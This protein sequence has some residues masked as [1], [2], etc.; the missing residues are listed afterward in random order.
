M[1]NHGEKINMF[2]TCICWPGWVCLYWENLCTWSRVQALGCTHLPKAQFFSKQTMWLVNN[3][4]LSYYQ[5]V[6][7]ECSQRQQY[8]RWVDTRFMALISIV[9]NSFRVPNTEYTCNKT[10]LQFS[11]RRG[12]GGDRRSQWGLGRVGDWRK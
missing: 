2:N 8:C 4:D 10:F 1:L 5:R 7:L 11:C 6:L 9:H 12:G 3:I